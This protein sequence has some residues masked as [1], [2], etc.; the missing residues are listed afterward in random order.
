MNEGHFK[1]FLLYVIDLHNLHIERKVDILANPL[2]PKR[3]EEIAKLHEECTLQDLNTL[4]LEDVE[5]VKEIKTV[6]QIESDGQV[7]GTQ[8]STKPLSEEETEGFT[9]DVNG[10]YSCDHCAGVFKRLGNVRN[11]LK[12]KH[13]IDYQLLCTCGKSFQ[14]SSK[15]SRHTKSC[16]INNK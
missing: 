8:L 5:T 11:H 2:N 6:E 15:Y 16:R 13:E 7:T 12:S 9:V 10:E 4:T 3:K 14:D 1:L